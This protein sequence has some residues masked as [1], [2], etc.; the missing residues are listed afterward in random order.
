MH[1]INPSSGEV[2]A[3]D[4]QGSVRAIDQAV[5]SYSR[6]CASVIEVSGASRLP[7]TTGQPALTRIAAGLAALIEGRAQIAEAT[8]DL[9]KVQGASTLKEVAFECPDGLPPLHGK[10]SEPVSADAVQA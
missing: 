2:I 7:V 1:H 5:L 10:A 4:T 9:R 3:A 8:R 6:L